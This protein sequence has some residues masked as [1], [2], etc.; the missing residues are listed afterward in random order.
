MPDGRVVD[1]DNNNV[2]H[3]E[4]QAWAMLMAAVQG[5]AASFQS[6]KAWT[7]A[8]LGIRADSLLAWRYRAWPN[9]GVDDINAAIDGDLCHAWALLRA[10][11]LWPGMG[12]A[13]RARRIAADIIRLAV[14]DINGTILLLPAPEGYLTGREVII[15]PSYYVFPALDAIE[16]HFPHPAWRTLISHGQALLE[17]A[18]FGPWG[19]P[20][21][22]LEVSRPG[23]QPR[24]QAGRGEYFGYDALRVPLYLAWSGRW[25]AAPVRAARDFWNA[26]AT[27]APPAW[28]RLTDGALAPYPG[29]AGLAAIHRLLGSGVGPALAFPSHGDGYY[30]RSLALLAEA[31]QREA[32][33]RLGGA[34]E[35]SLNNAKRREYLA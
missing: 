24:P 27:P 9:R 5:D 28:V 26:T 6:I 22:W 7:D 33:P 15:N 12:Y 4:G 29:G 14:R 8:H 10:E 18:R 2:S 30:Q 11:R 23:M 16:A 17:R 25:R 13:A 21:D 20:P 3:S 32:P 35:P 31:A 1:T 34:L 19:L